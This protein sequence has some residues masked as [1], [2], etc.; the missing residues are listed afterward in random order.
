MTLPQ[1]CIWDIS[2]P[3]VCKKELSEVVLLLP[4]RSV[5]RLSKVV[6]RLVKVLSALVLEDEEVDV[7]DESDEELVLLLELDS[8]LDRLWIRLCRPL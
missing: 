6:C 2:L 1:G 3:R 5:T 4:P 7:P 8:A